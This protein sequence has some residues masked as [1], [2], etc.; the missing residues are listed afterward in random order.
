MT[1]DGFNRGFVQGNR[2]VDI[3]AQIAI[4]NTLS[5]PK[6]E[7]IDYEGNDV[8]ITWVCGA[9]QFVATGVFLKDTEDNAG[10]IGDE[11]KTTF[12]F[13]AIRIADAVGN[14]SLFDLEL[15]GTVGEANGNA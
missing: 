1:N 5:R 4:Q 8:S 9:D 12:N 7:N 6:L 13:G 10:G 15:G 11:V 14:S 2:D 3:T